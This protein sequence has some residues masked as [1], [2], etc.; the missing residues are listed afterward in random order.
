MT[1]KI[2]FRPLVF[3]VASSTFA[4]ACDDA[5]TVGRIDSN[6]GSSGTSVSGGGG[7]GGSL[8]TGGQPLD[9]GG[10]TS[11]STTGS[12]G[13]APSGGTSAATTVPTY[14]D[15]ATD[16]APPAEDLAVFVS[17]SLGD[18]ANGLGTALAPFKTIA[19]ALDMEEAKLQS[20]TRFIIIDEGE[21]SPPP[22]IQTFSW[23]HYLTLVGGW[24][25]DGAKWKRDCENGYRSRTVIGGD[26]AI[27]LKV[28][29]SQFLPLTIVALTIKTKPAGATVPGQPGESLYGVFVNGYNGSITFNDVDIVVGRAGNGGDVVP[30]DAAGNVLCDGQTC[31]GGGTP[32]PGNNGA[33]A[34]SNGTYSGGFVP[35]NGSAGENGS[36]G[37][38]G[39]PGTPGAEGFCVTSCTGQCT[40]SPVT[41]DMGSHGAMAGATGGLCGCG[42]LG[43]AGGLAG[44]GGGAAVG[45]YLWGWLDR[46]SFTNTNIVVA[47]GGDGSAGSRG[48]AGGP[49]SAGQAGKPSGNCP[50]NCGP[51]S[52]AG[53]GCSC[54]P[55]PAI[56]PAGAAGTA[57][58]AGSPGG[59]GGA[60]AGGDAWAI[61]I[62]PQTS[63]YANSI[64]LSTTIGPAG[65]GAV[66]A[67]AGRSG[68]ELDL[69]N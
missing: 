8:S 14:N 65:T 38:N 21:Y 55:I 1:S 19:Q 54:A 2:G 48:G 56:Y 44:K 59:D 63:L 51:S 68:T 52:A 60:G 49:G 47:G 64:G 18:D 16:A 42:G 26:A 13:G 6:A 57:G 58:A 61:V 7:G 33:A 53:D 43:G 46:A 28:E 17:A 22:V 66:G 40:A 50:R 12:T 24:K 37:P 67:V 32:A 35:S 9:T 36:S 29:E 23:K 62:G 39:S 20:F 3:L 5:N 11:I 4:S 34:T 41:C 31:P 10:T 45:V 25:F 30:P 15:C 69:S 27:G